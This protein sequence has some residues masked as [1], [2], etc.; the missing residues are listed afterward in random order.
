MLYPQPDGSVQADVL[1]VLGT[2]NGFWLVRISNE[3]AE[4][5]PANSRELLDALAD[6]VTQ[7]ARAA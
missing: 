6:L 3:T 7:R 1:I 5:T 2:A 4:M